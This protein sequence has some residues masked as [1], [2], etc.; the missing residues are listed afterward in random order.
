MWDVAPMIVSEVHYDIR[1]YEKSVHLLVCSAA[2]KVNLT[3][4]QTDFSTTPFLHN[5]L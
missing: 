1:P 2:K 5:A 4:I 3:G